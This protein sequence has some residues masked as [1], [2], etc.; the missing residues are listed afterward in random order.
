MSPS[1]HS[2]VQGIASQQYSVCGGAIADGIMNVVGITASSAGKGLVL[3]VGRRFSSRTGNTVAAQQ[4]RLSLRLDLSTVAGGWSDQTLDSSSIKKKGEPTEGADRPATRVALITPSSRKLGLEAVQRWKLGGG[5]S[6]SSTLRDGSCRVQGRTRMATSEMAEPAPF[7][8]AHGRAIK[9]NHSGD[10]GIRYQRKTTKVGKPRG[11]SE[12]A[13]ALDDQSVA[14]ARPRQVGSRAR[15]PGAASGGSTKAHDHRNGDYSRSKSDEATAVTAPTPAAT[16]S[17]LKQ[18]SLMRSLKQAKRRRDSE[19]AKRILED[20]LAQDDAA[21]VV[22]VFVFSATIGIFAKT[23]QWEAAIGVLGI[24]REKGVQ[25]NEFTY[26]QAITACGNG[27][28][29][30]WAIYLL[31][32][33]PKMGVSPDVISY[34]AAIGACARGKQSELAVVLLRE[35]TEAG[36]VAPNALT[37]STVMSVVA[38]TSGT[39]TRTT[40]ATAAGAAAA[41]DATHW[42]RVVGLLEEMRGKEITPDATGYGLAVAACAAGGQA[43]MAV[44]LLRQMRREDQ[45][46]PDL[47]SYNAA[48]KACNKAGKWELAVVLLGEAKEAEGVS[49]DSVTYTEVIEA[50]RKGGQPGLAAVLLKEMQEAGI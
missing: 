36:R 29:W 30:R 14:C 48:M 33:M 1:V 16:G 2:R 35:M 40:A 44:K 5:S 24:M 27:G 25:P 8:S 7:C 31:K 22:D 20:A 13:E 50:C 42:K 21:E 10:R 4:Q 38:E 3:Q 39:L 6:S 37:Y 47:K 9:G 49:P 41:P 46:T 43:D 26:N 45:V 18:A 12:R 11:R 23:G 17:Q 28:A 15:R 19:E 32:A 34:N